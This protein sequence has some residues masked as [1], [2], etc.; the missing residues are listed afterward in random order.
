MR[1]LLAAALAASM[2]TGV[3]GAEHT[4]AMLA[5][6]ASLPHRFEPAFLKIAPGDTVIFPASLHHD[7]V[8]IAGGTPEGA[9]GWRGNIDEEVRVTLT[10]EGLYAYKCSPHYFE[11]MVGLIQ[12]GESPANAEAIAALKLLGNAEG[13]MDELLALAIV[14]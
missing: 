14:D 8:S 11:G 2:A 3:A 9:E 10:V 5:A 7:S 4:I 13:R 12:V 1:I 6:D